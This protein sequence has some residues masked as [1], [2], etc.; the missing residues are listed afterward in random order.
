MSMTEADW[1]A[2][3]W[4][5]DQ[6]LYHS[7]LALEEFT[8][9][10]LTAYFK[11]RPNVAQAPRA[12]TR[13]ASALK[14]THPTSAFLMAAIALEVTVKDVFLRP[15]VFGLVHS[16][17]AAGLIT[18]MAIRVTRY[19]RLQD[20]LFPLL[21]EHAKLD[22]RGMRRTTRSPQLVAELAEIQSLRNQVVH[23]AVAAKLEDAERAVASAEYLLDRALPV[24]TRNLGL[25]LHADHSVCSGAFCFGTEGVAILEGEL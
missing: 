17:A 22:F 24:L 15:I 10:R 23:S 2:E 7:K 4:A 25:H 1:Q 18:D 11:S 19:D 20:L 12:F 3:D 21:H 14:G 5:L 13:E 6:Y 9:E 8:A 16:D